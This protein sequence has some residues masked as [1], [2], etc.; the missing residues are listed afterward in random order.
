VLSEILVKRLD[1]P[2]I[3]QLF[4]GFTGYQLFCLLHENPILT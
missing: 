3:N 2:Y 1:N 4:P